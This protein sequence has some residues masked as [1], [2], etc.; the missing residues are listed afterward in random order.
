[1]DPSKS[2]HKSYLLEWLDPQIYE[3]EGALIVAWDAVGELFPDGLLD[4][5]FDSYCRLLQRL[6]DDDAAWQEAWPETARQL[7]P[8]RQ[9]EQRAAVNHTQA[10]MT[11]DLLHTLFV[12]QVPQRR[13][14][15]AVITTDRTVTYEELH[16]GANR[17]GH[18]LRDQGAQPNTLVAVVMEKGWEQV[19][20]V[21]GVLASGAAY[22]P[23]DAALPKDR[24]WHLLQHGEV[25]F[26]LTQPQFETELEW[27]ETIKR[28]T[29]EGS[30]LSGSDDQPLKPVQSPEDLAYVIYTSGSTGVPKGVMIDHRGAVNTILDLNQRF[31]VRSEDRVLAL[32]SLSF[33]LSVY[34]IFGILAA[35]GAIVVP[36]AADLR[37]P[38]HWADMVARHRVTVWNSVP[39]LMQ[40]LV[41]YTQGRGQ[42]LARDLRLVFMS[43]DWIPVALPQ[44]IRALKDDVEIISMGGATEASI[45]SI[46]YPIEAVPSSWKSIPYGRP[47]V[48][49]TFHVL[50]ETLEPCPVWVP[51]QLFIGGI[52][53][54][55]GYW[56]DEEKTRAS[57]IEHPRTG[58]RLYRTGD[59]GRYLPDGN[60][61][62]LGRDD[63]QVKVQGYRVELEE[64][65]AILGQNPGVRSSVVTALGQAFGNKRLVAYV[66]PKQDPPPAASELVRFLGERL[67]TYMV[68]QTYVMLDHLPLSPNG[69]VDRRALP[70]PA[71]P[72]AEPPEKPRAERTRESVRLA[73]LVAGVLKLQDVDPDDSLF[74]LGAT[75]IDMIRIVNAVEQEMG[76]RPKMETLYR[77]PTVA[78]LAESHQQ[79]LRQ[80]SPAANEDGYEEGVL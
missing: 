39:A 53:L 20:S 46:I 6:T 52:G 60:I 73:K 38:A 44:Q 13:N 61:E 22:V 49:Q 12:E 65:E 45:W 26:V 18:W 29:V 32:S 11:D 24:L 8:A 4:D 16:R 21:L 37:D 72:S 35:G 68:P 7:M 34:D 64:I 30:C 75:S 40:M 1:M 10:P 58:E 74:D 15:A 5:M 28:L 19:A 59:Q 76:F 79:H 31:R 41:E 56:R 62:F 55:K 27:P 43:G 2:I 67:P 77:F 80:N 25:Q 23:I 71:A 66:V 48:N 54:A 57:F 70:E 3:D 33:D 14:Q 42:P 17:I 9:L 36:N 63:F 50:S 47:M 51:G 69:K 78:T